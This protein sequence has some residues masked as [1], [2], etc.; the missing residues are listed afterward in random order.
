MLLS[1]N[2]HPAE[3][4]ADGHAKKKLLALLQ[5]EKFH[6]PTAGISLVD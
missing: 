5:S 6:D 2:L 3:I 4:K 1:I